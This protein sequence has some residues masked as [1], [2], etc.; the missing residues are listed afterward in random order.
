LGFP[1]VCQHHVARVWN[2]EPWRAQLLQWRRSVSP[3]RRRRRRRHEPDAEHD[4]WC[5]VWSNLATQS[6]C[7]AAISSSITTTL[8][9]S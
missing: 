5:Q 2:P 4:A 3:H 1:G 9:P 6:V 7:P 8:G